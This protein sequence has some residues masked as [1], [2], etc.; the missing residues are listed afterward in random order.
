MPLAVSFRS[1]GNFIHMAEV[2]VQVH[3]MISHLYLTCF[4]FASCLT[5]ERIVY[6]TSGHLRNN[7]FSIS[8]LTAEEIAKEVEANEKIRTRL[9]GKTKPVRSLCESSLCVSQWDTHVRCSPSLACI[10]LRQ[11]WL[12]ET[13]WNVF[14]RVRWCHIPS[15]PLV[16]VPR[17]IS[18]ISHQSR[19]ADGS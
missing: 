19:L 16:A 15:M 4:Q 8:P 10:S 17:S 18:V 7:R 5:I 2:C 6:N 1:N 9:Q 12:S 13:E 14:I 11:S 3:N